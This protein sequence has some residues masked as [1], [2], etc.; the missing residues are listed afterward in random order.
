[1]APSQIKGTWKSRLGEVNNSHKDT[2]SGRFYLHF[3]MFLLYKIINLSRTNACRNANVG[4]SISFYESREW[5]EP[6]QLRDIS[7]RL[8]DCAHGLSGTWQVNSIIQ[9]WMVLQLVYIDLDLDLLL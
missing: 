1:M 6:I 9:I 2:V 7:N 8:F 4:E 3:I 5:R